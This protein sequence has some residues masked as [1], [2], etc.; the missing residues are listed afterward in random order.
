MQSKA[1]IIHRKTL[2]CLLTWTNK[3]TKKEENSCYS[4]EEMTTN[5]ENLINI[6]S[7]CGER[8]A[9]CKSKPTFF[10]GSKTIAWIVWV[11][12][13]FIFGQEINSVWL[14]IFK[15]FSKQ[16]TC[17]WIS[18]ESSN[19]MH[20]RSQH[21]CS[22]LWVHWDFFDKWNN[23]TEFLYYESKWTG[24]QMIFSLHS[25]IRDS[26]SLNESS[27]VKHDNDWNIPTI[28]RSGC[29]FFTQYT[30]WIR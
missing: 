27:T 23:Q 1:W 30:H 3:Q 21:I 13:S 19:C 7:T 9:Y 18:C 22:S 24:F 28:F 20:P 2:P 6:R 25:R 11:S 26:N 15:N 8:F 4:L 16:K 12:F 29:L 5:H 10:I 14:K 17:S